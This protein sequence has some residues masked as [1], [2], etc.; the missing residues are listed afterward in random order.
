[1]LMICLFAGYQFALAQTQQQV[2]EDDDVPPGWWVIPKTDT[3]IKLGGY[4]KLDVIHD[5]NPI[6]SPYFFDVTEIPTDGSEGQTT[7]LNAR[8]SRLHLDVRQ[9]SGIGE[10][11][12]YVEGDFYGTNGAFRLRHAFL[13]LGEHWR[14][15]QWWSNFMDEDMIP[16][17]LDFEKPGAYAFRRAAMVRYKTDVSPNAYFAIAIEQPSN[18]GIDLPETGQYERPYPDLTLR[19]RLTG[20]WG[21]LQ[22]SALAAS[23]RYRLATGDTENLFL[24]GGNVSGSFNVFNSDKFSYQVVYGPGVGRARGGISAGPDENGELSAFTDLGM[25]ASYKHSWSEKFSSL[26][27]FNY[28]HVGDPGGIPNTTISNVYY[29]AVNLIWHVT[30][31]SFVGLEYLHGGREDLSTADGTANRIQLS[32]KHSFN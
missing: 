4:V 2:V 13:E 11:R 19:Y 32:L 3:R 25:T 24:A 29:G 21:H 23:I 10:L 8:E 15:G 12:I 14:A 27:V 26:L 30:P 16:A 28:G 20:K 6:G 5:L 7:T 22:L 18:G 9:P 1:M 31:S 17:T